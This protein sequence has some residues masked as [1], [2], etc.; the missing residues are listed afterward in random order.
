M[1]EKSC[2]ATKMQ[3]NFSHFSHFLTT[4]SIQFNF[5]LN[6]SMN[7]SFTKILSIQ[8]KDVLRVSPHA[9]D[10]ADMLLYCKTNPTQRHLVATLF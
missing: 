9:A 1:T 5:F 4:S 6:Y 2:Y 8:C 3:P 10:F 7:Y